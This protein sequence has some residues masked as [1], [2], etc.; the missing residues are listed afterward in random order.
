[1]ANEKVLKARVEVEAFVAEAQN[2]LANFKNSMDEMWKHSSPPKSLQKQYESL[3]TRLGSL[4]E[5]TSQGLLNSSELAQAASDYKAIKSEIHNLVVEY[6][7]LSDAQKIALLDPKVRQELAAR[8]AALKKYND[9]LAKNKQALK[10]KAELEDKQKA[11]SRSNVGKKGAV[12]KLTKQV[13]A[14]EAPVPNDEAKQYLA[15]QERLKKVLDDIAATQKT[16]NDLST[17]GKQDTKAYNNAT[18]YLAELEQQKEALNGGQEAYN[19]YVAAMAEYEAK[20]APL[21]QKIEELNAEIAAGEDEIEDYQKKINKL[22]TTTP[23]KAFSDLKNTLSELGVGGLENVNT[24]EELQ[25]VLQSLSANALSGVNTQIDSTVN[26]LKQMGGAA[27]KVKEQIDGANHVIEEQ[28]K[29]LADLKA[30]GERAKQ[31]LGLAGAVEVLKNAAR[32]AFQAVTEL[33][34][35]MTEMSVVTDLSIGDYWEQLPEH[36]ARASELG[37][38]IKDVYEAETLYYQQGLKTNEVVAISTETL[39]MARI[40]GL[41]AEDATQKMTAALRGFNMEINET[42]A[43][44]VADVY[45]ELAAI[46]AAD[47]GQISN[48]MSKTA[49]IASSAGMEFETTAAFLS[50]IIETTQESAETAGTAMKTVVARFQELKKDPADI[51]EVDGEIVDANAIETALRSVGVSLRDASGQFRDLDDVFLELSSKWDSLDKNTQRYIATIAAGSRQQ[52]R[53]IAMMSDYGRTQELVTAANNSAGASQKQYE[54]TLDSLESKL[55]ELKNAWQEFTMGIMNSEFLKAGVDILTKLLTIINK[56]TTGFG[57]FSGA[58]SKIAVVITILKTAE[59]LINKVMTSLSNKA[60]AFGRDLGN[61]IAEGITAGMK[62]GEAAVE[63][64]QNNMKQKAEDNSQ[65]NQPQ[66]GQSGTS[67]PAEAPQT[68]PTQDDL[69]KKSHGIR[70]M[71]QGAST[72]HEA[73]QEQKSLIQEANYSRVY[74]NGPVGGSMKTAIATSSVGGKQ[75]GQKLAAKAFPDSMWKNVEKQFKTKMKDMGKSTEEIEDAWNKTAKNISKKG[76][77]AVDVVEDLDKQLGEAAKTAEKDGKK[78]PDSFQQITVDADDSVKSVKDL[79]EGIQA[80]TTKS[81]EGLKQMSTSMVN[82]GMAVTGVGLAFGA[83]GSVF[84]EMGLNGVAEAFNGIGTVLTTVGGVVSTVGGV[85]GFL[86]TILT[87]NIFASLSVAAAN[88]VQSGSWLGVAVSAIVA[89]TAMSPLLVITLM[90]AAAI[91][92]LVAVVLILVAV[93][94]AIKNSTPEAKLEKA[95]EATEAA[96]EA[97]DAAAEAYKNLEDAFDSLSSKYDALEDLTQGTREWRDAVKEINDEVLTLIDEYPEL[98]ALVTNE[99]GVLK[100]DLESDE[101]QAVLDD[102]E[103]RAMTA[104]SAE[105]ASKIS[106]LQ[107][108]TEVDKKSLSDAATVQDETAIGWIRGL[109]VANMVLPGGSTAGVGGL[110]AAEQMETQG[111]KDTEALATALAEGLVT[112]QA[113]GSWKATAGSEDRLLELGLSASEAERFAESLGEGA[114]ELKE[115]GKEVAKRTEQEKA[116]YEA[117]A[118]NAVQMVDTADM[119]AEEIQQVNIAANEEYMRHFTEAK[120]EDYANWSTEKIESKAKEI[121]GDSAKVDKNG[122]VTVGEGD[123][124]KT[125][126]SKEFKKQAAASDATED[127]AEALENLPKAIDSVADKMGKAG[128]SFEK[129]YMAE[130]GKGLTKKDISNL[131]KYSDKELETIWNEQLTDTEREA[132]GDLELFK[133][134]L[135]ESVELSEKAFENANKTLNEMNVNV[136]FHENMTAEAAA[137]Y[138]KQLENIMAG[139]G[140]SGVDAVDSAMDALADSMDEEKFN[141]LMSHINSIEWKNMDEWDKLPDTL[142]QVGLGAYA[143]SE[144]LQAFITAAQESAGAIRNIN[145]DK[146]NEQMQELQSISNKIK[147]GEQGRSFDSSSYEAI[148]EAIPK[149]AGQFQQT[150]EGEYVYLGDSM[151]AL[152]EAIHENTAALLGQATDQLQNK[153]DAAETMEDMTGSWWKSGGTKYTLDIEN[154]KSWEDDASGGSSAK[155]YLEHFI[156]EANADEVD[157]KQLGIAGLTNYTN[158]ASLNDEQI[159]LMMEDLQ[160]IY[161]DLDKNRKLLDEKAINAQALTYQNQDATTNSIRA[162]SYRKTIA[163]GGTINDEQR[164]QMEGSTRALTAQA[165]V[166]GVNTQDINNYTE[167]L[168]EMD[169][170]EEAYKSGKISLNEYTT[171]YKKLTQEAEKFERTVTNKNNLKKMNNNLQTSIGKIGEL[172]EGF[173]GLE[174]E[175]TKIERV[176][177]MV[178]DFGVEVDSSNYEQI[179][180]WA[181]TLSQGGEEAE[182]AMEKL[183]ALSGQ[184]YGLSMEQITTMTHTNFTDTTYQM[185]KEMQEFTEKMVASGLGMWQELEDGSKRFAFSTAE[186]LKDAAAAAGTQSEKWDISYDM[187][188][189]YS[190]Q[191]NRTI[192]ERDKLERK[193]NDLLKSENITAAALLENQEKKL[194]SLKEQSGYE[195]A[196]IAE[197]YGKIETMFNDP[198]YAEFAKYTRYD[199]TTQ[200]FTDDTEGLE[201]AETYWTDEKQEEFESWRAELE[202]SNNMV[203]DAKKS[204]YDIK[205]Q[206][207]EIAEQGK[208]ATSDLYDSIREGII[209]ERQEQIDELQNINDSIQSAEDSLI[210]KI[211]DQINEARQQKQMENAEKDLAD[212]MSYLTYLQADSSGSNELEARLLQEEI[213]QSKEDLMEAKIDQSIAN[214]SEASAE[215]A[216]QRQHQI[217]IAQQQLDLYASSSEIWTDVQTILNDS[218]MQAAAADDWAAAWQETDAFRYATEALISDEM[219]PIKQEELKKALNEDGAMS[220]IYYDL[221]SMSTNIGKE[222][223]EAISGTEETEGLIGTLGNKLLGTEDQ[224][225]VKHMTEN[226]AKLVEAI[227]GPEEGEAA[228]I[229]EQMAETLYWNDSWGSGYEAKIDVLN[230]RTWEDDASHSSIENYLTAL[231]NQA[232]TRGFDLSSLGIDNLSNYSDLASLTEAQLKDIMVKL[233]NIYKTQKDLFGQETGKTSDIEGYV[234]KEDHET[235]QAVKSHKEKGQELYEWIMANTQNANWKE[236]AKAANKILQSAGERDTSTSSSQFSALNTIKQDIITL[237]TEKQNYAKDIKAWLNAVANN[238]TWTNSENE[239]MSAF[240]TQVQQAQDKNTALK[241]YNDAKELYNKEIAEKAAADK[242]AAAAK[243][244]AEKEAAKAETSKIAKSDEYFIKGLTSNNVLE[245]G[246]NFLHAA[247]AGMFGYDS[248]GLAD[249]TG[250]A[251]LD[252]TKARPEMVLNP[253]DTQNFIQLKDILSD[254]LT[255]TNT[256]NKN[257]SNQ[258]SQANTFDIDINIE[259]I[260]DD[261]DVEELAD[262]IRSMLYTD[263]SYRNVN[264]ISRMR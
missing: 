134:H 208:E 105:I 196:A 175:A 216:E 90:I 156:K 206:V 159:K 47:V 7:T 11:I 199:A 223:D 38:A 56:V 1:M 214:M 197:G 103:A 124:A 193:Y 151:S 22:K 107:A 106:T 9:T 143:N 189:N 87:S 201:G 34:K 97:A 138:A 140:Q 258:T 74:N 170:L 12:T 21:Q 253:Q 29:Q 118:L 211:Q 142:E 155:S 65:Q 126:T 200:T 33:D 141:K 91:L 218:L 215:A 114:D 171:Q 184:Q 213:K 217:D 130:D 228:D 147:S 194:A 192:R 235:K 94:K 137:G 18:A 14:V 6:G 191:V 257:E 78:I 188:N 39:K 166:A 205:D 190:E 108:Q 220:A 3:K 252:G 238:S 85:L 149:M 163:E 68:N 123:N 129:T 187:M 96:G 221:N 66:N 113:D 181:I 254:I 177:D 260:S 209:L 10:E 102:Y 241:A 75:N 195:I 183:V 13:Q 48:A 53:F 165:V 41:S 251:W 121:Y 176:A 145:L 237:R 158:V 67:A 55:N 132:F 52:S 25:N 179:G 101:A 139:S 4:Q 70:G 60:K 232:N 256:I 58:F 227:L 71:F 27:D 88:V 63:E 46:T 116:L 131:N 98:A 36:T 243:E 203:K 69:K 117:M 244:A 135:K 50:Q 150:L 76:V 242:A 225:L 230:W 125:I 261:Y 263:A 249:F 229:M 31:F 109:S 26:G 17:K 95:Q 219:N 233:E 234:S 146:L 160:S 133:E 16:I 122:N 112:E 173:S 178:A 162:S 240:L 15:N 73:N 81:A 93:F 28:N 99:D 51:G 83:M 84:E 72:I 111:E 250:P 245:K 80:S 259:K 210:G 32:G 54:K 169:K 168:S 82:V 49:S 174:N 248:G 40:A 164:M 148:V 247:F 136:Q 42:S 222:I 89:Q 204:L 182:K 45:S 144:A 185:S 2:E 35:V 77:K 119:Q 236:E 224:S 226:N 212:Q 264:N 86:N 110:I 239:Q 30:F 5:I 44:N 128:R 180:E 43:Q 59:A 57:S 262:K 92:A 23:E 207:D 127:A 161:N 115:Y 231:Q 255:G 154:W 167:V 100:I 61:S 152:T 186:N 24:L 62:K 153:V 104:S 246:W 157:L 198:K 19:E 20:I 8:E 37:V 120:E 64:S 172:T 79:E 202:E